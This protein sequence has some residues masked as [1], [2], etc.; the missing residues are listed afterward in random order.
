MNNREEILEGRLAVKELQKFYV[1]SVVENLPDIVKD[2]KKILLDKIN[3]YL[4]N[5]TKT[6]YD[7]NGNPYEQIIS[8]PVV[9][10]KYFFCTVNPISGQ[11]MLYNAETLGIIFDLY[12]EICSM[13]NERIGNFIPTLTSF[14]KFAGITIPTFRSYC[15]SSDLELRVVSQKIEDYCFDISVTASQMG[16]AKESITKYRMKTE[17]GK[18][19]KEAPQIHIHKENYIDVNE[20][21]NRLSSLIN[22]NGKKVLEAKIEENKNE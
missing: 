18:I 6:L 16:I 22:Y 17:L 15:E 12:E 4:K 9:I 14:C 8:N 1:E 13:V 7:K 21:T 2:R 19:E 20:I 5:N 3:E 10:N 11:E